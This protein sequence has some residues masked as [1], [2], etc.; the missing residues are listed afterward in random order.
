MQNIGEKIYNLRKEKNV[1]QEKLANQLYVARQ[2]VSKWETNT[3]QPSMENLDGMCKFFDV[4]ISYFFNSEKNIEAAAS[5][6]AENSVDAAEKAAE[7]SVTEQPSAGRYSTLKILLTVFGIVLLVLCVIACGIAAYLIIDSVES[8]YDDSVYSVN[9]LGIIFLVVGI[10]V[11]AILITLAV[12]FIKKWLK[13]K[14][15]K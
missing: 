12:I 8:G 15:N 4:D 11:T 2:T 7:A 5:E 13:N 10:L 3:A 1:S 9:Y 6:T 14:K